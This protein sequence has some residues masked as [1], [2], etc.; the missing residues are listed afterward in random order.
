MT[1]TRPAPPDQA[2]DRLAEW[3]AAGL[4]DPERPDAADRLALLEFLTEAGAG[5]A[6]MVEAQ[7]RDR[8]FALAGDRIIR[9]PQPRRTPAEAA[10]ALGTDAQ[11][12]ERAW[13]AFGLPAPAGAA[14]DARDVET[15]RTWLRVRDLMGEAAALGLARVLGAGTARLA[16]A[17][18]AALRTSLHG[19]VD[20]AHTGSEAVTARA[21]A[22]VAELVP[23]IGT[24]L[25]TVHR[26]HIEAARRHFEQVS[27][28][29]GD[30]LRC[31]I[32]FADLSD[33]T[34]MVQAMPLADLSALLAGFDSA[35]SAAVGELGGRVVKFLGDAVMFVA[36]TPA[37]LARIAL[38][39][40][41]HPKAAEAGLRVRAGVCFGDVLAQDGDYFGPPVNLAARLVAAA[42]PGEVLTDAASAGLLGAG[43]SAAAG[44]PR[45]LRG[46]PGE[47]TPYAVAR[48]LNP[49]PAA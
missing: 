6:E 11:T 15:V 18:S 12:V 25:D 42:E 32:G 21:Y 34:P 40:V 29:V 19:Q 46:I 5:L 17:E 2:G 36:P 41:Q 39:L 37:L 27:P 35:A 45:R 28:G 13:R 44:P 8:L 7:E 24:M 30:A 16:E 1:A 31:G 3:A 9:P 47:V 43:F 38:A 33:F 49:D 22:T 23:R 48:A 20:R 10:A 4:Y 26:H 14:L